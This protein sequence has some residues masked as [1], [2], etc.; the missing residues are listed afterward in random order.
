MF[1]SN[2]DDIYVYT[3]PRGEHLDAFIIYA[4]AGDI[5]YIDLYEDFEHIMKHFNSI[6]TVSPLVE[7][8]FA[9]SL[10]CNVMK[11][12]MDLFYNNA[13]TIGI[14]TRSQ[15]NKIKGPI[16]WLKTTNAS[17]IFNHCQLLKF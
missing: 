8:M 1:K 4:P 2:Q 10:K 13:D 16:V 9:C 7:T 15:D 12:S 14:R 11:T 3:A 6:T 5:D 17:E